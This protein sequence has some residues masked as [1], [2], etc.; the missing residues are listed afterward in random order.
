MLTRMVCVKCGS[1]FDGKWS[2]LPVCD[3]CEKD[4]KDPFRIALEHRRILR[5]FLN[6]K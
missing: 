5:R 2:S 4:S 6:K 3:D 1:A